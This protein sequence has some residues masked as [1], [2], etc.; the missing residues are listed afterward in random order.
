MST[1]KDKILYETKMNL[2]VNEEVGEKT[3]LFTSIIITRKNNRFIPT[4]TTIIDKS[5]KD[6]MKDSN[7]D[8]EKMNNARR[9][10]SN[11]IAEILKTL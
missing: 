6:K 11:S 2:E 10:L 9:E 4:Y 3:I 8:Y 7:I 5:L 1:I